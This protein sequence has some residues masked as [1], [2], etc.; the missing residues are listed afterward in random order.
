[1]LKR[2]RIGRHLHGDRWFDITSTG[3]LRRKRVSAK[4]EQQFPK[5]LRIIYQKHGPKGLDDHLR[6]QGYG[7]VEAWEKIKH[8][9]ND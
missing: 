5:E 9:F 1:M 7:F 6:E 3:T 4:M 8:M 2:V